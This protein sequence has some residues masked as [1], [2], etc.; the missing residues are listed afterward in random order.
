MSYAQSIQ[1]YLKKYLIA[2]T[3]YKLGDTKTWV[4]Y[5]HFPPVFNKHK[6][7]FIHGEILGNAKTPTHPSKKIEVVSH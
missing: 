2:P 7:L 6:Q 4:K 1:S 3:K 5:T